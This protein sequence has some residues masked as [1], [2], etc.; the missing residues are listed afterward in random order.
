[1]IMRDWKKAN[2]RKS[3]YHVDFSRYIYICIGV[4]VFEMKCCMS[5]ASVTRRGRIKNEIIHRRQ[6][7]CRIEGS[8]LGYCYLI[9]G[10]NAKWSG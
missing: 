5:M 1:M 6:Q 3:L 4:N 7:S 2:S 10:I 9:E 8:V